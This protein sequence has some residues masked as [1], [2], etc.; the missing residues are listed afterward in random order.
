MDKWTPTPRAPTFALTPILEP[1]APFQDRMLVRCRA[2]ISN[3]AERVTRRSGRRSSACLHRVAHRRARENDRGRRYPGRHLDRS[4]RGARVRQVDAARL[5][6]ARHGLPGTGG[7]V[8]GRLFLRV[9]QHDLLA[10]DTTPMPME[11]RPRAIFER[12]F[13]DS[14]TTDP[15]LRLAR[16]EENRSILDA[17]ARRTRPA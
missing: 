13:G 6:R 9:L 14:G 15:K 12:L 2:S 7:R 17:V 1:L 16:I 11:N 4:D 5:A 8:R 3:Q 10:H